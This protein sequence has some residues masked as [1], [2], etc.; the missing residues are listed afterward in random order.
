MARVS[1][2]PAV[3]TLDKKR[4]GCAD[5]QPTWPSR[6]NEEI[7]YGKKASHPDPKENQTLYPGIKQGISQEAMGQAPRGARICSTIYAVFPMFFCPPN[8]LRTR[9]LELTVNLRLDAPGGPAW[10]PGGML[11][12][13]TCTR[14]S[15][16]AFLPHG[17]SR[18]FSINTGPCRGPHE[19]PC[20]DPYARWCGGTG[21]VT[22]PPTRSH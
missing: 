14:P 22:F 12:P 21:R 5:R 7:F 3:A 10:G 11:G 1:A 18:T 16:T 20:T 6:S 17:D 2:L 19:P 8:H 9:Q 4:H 15:I 13:R